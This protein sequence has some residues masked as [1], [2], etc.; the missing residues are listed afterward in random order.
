MLTRRGIAALAIVIAAL[1]PGGPA[2]AQGRLVVYSANDANLNRFVFEAFTRETGIEVEPVE[3]GSGVVFRRIASERER[4]LGDVVWGVSRALLTAN[5]AL[6]APYAS[7]NKD[8][9]PAEFRDAEDH[10]I[11]TNVHLL[12]ILQNTKLVAADAGPKTWADL[13]DP[14]WKGKIAFSD[15]ANSGSAF[16]NLTM[17]ADLWGGGEAGWDKVGQLLANTKVLNRSTLVF[18]GVG[19]GEF[20]LGMSLEYAGLLW[21]SNGAPVKVVYPQDG[22]VAQMEGVGIIKDGPNPQSAKAFVDYITRKDVREAILRFAFRR[23]TRQDL[24]LAKLPGQMPA[25]ADVKLISYDEAGWGARRAEALQK[26]QDLVR[27]TR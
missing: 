2:A 16:T 24:D 12:V 25:L 9:M 15:P 11:G 14:Q 17:L 19:N 4:P 18:Q 20:A 10:W 26:I 13:L 7:K 6:L 21:A 5:R 1:A 22:T 3:G 8:A 23:A 27:R